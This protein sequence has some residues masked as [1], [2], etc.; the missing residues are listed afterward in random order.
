MSIIERLRRVTTECKRLS[1]GSS[2]T[3]GARAVSRYAK[4]SLVY[5]WL[6]M[7][8]ETIVVVVDLSETTILWPLLEV[9]DG[10]QTR[11]KSAWRDSLVGRTSDVR[12]HTDEKNKT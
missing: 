12:S 1:S 10:V 6:V 7:E 5:D 11:I 2:V 4:E 8:R 3:R 9:I